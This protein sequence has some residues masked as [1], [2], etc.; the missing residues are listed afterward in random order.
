MIVANTQEYQRHCRV[1][2]YAIAGSPTM[3]INDKTG[4]VPSFLNGTGAYPTP[5]GLIGAGQS[6]TTFT[7]TL[8]QIGQLF[9]SDIGGGAGPTG[10]GDTGFGVGHPNG[11]DPVLSHMP[12]PTFPIWLLEGG[13]IAREILYLQANNAIGMVSYLGQRNILIGGTTYYAT[14]TMDSE[15]RTNAW[16]MRAYANAAYAAP[17]GSVEQTYFE[18]VC[19]SNAAA[20]AALKTYY[21]ANYSNLGFS[22]YGQSDYPP[23]NTNWRIGLPIS[24]Y[25]FGYQCLA[26]AW[27]DLLIGDR[28]AGVPAVA[29]FVGRAVNNLFNVLCPYFATNYIYGISTSDSL[30]ASPPTVVSSAADIGMGPGADQFFSYVNGGTDVTWSGR[31]PEWTLAIGDR[32]RPQN[33]TNL[34]V[35]CPS[36]A[37]PLSDG[38]GYPI[39][40]VNLGAKTFKLNNGSGSPITF[41]QTVNLSGGWL[42]PTGQSC[43]ATLD[44][45]DTYWDPDGYMAVWAAAT[46]L[47]AIRGTTGGA[48]AYD[49]ASGRLNFNR[50]TSFPG[51]TYNTTSMWGYTRTP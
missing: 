41:T 44:V 46:A 23:T 28:V 37:L 43:P 42:M 29:D 5:A 6:G 13:A 40:S 20:I 38:T 27:A 3:V 17:D 10:F 1:P 25:A 34:T 8:W 4:K 45:G 12:S 14:G 49:A 15:N 22:F 19:G 18:T 24:Q 21:G 36:A 30:S 7:N 47:H 32:F 9:S 33:Y 2:A 11:W 35:A 16:N 26:Y 31:D 39:L 51:G 50:P 48:A